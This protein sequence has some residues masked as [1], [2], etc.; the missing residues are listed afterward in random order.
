MKQFMNVYIH[1]LILGFYFGKEM[2]I[3]TDLLDETCVQP[4]IPFLQWWVHVKLH[5]VVSV[6]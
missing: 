3:I 4:F 1:N 6:I 5:N 2:E